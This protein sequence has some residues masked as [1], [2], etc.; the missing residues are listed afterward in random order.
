MN[1]KYELA[2]F[3]MDGTILDTLEDLTDATNYVLKQFGKPER[4]TKEV[5]ELLGNGMRYLLRMAAGGNTSDDEVKQMI[6]VFY[7]YY[8]DHAAI[9][10]K[11]YDGIVKA[12]QD[13]RSRGIRTAVVSNKP[14]VAVRDLSQMY[15][16]GLFDE[17]VGAS[18]EV[19][20]KPSPDGVNLVLQRLGVDRTNAVYIG[21]SEVDYATSQNAQMDVIM[22]SWG[23]R[24]KEDILKLG[25]P[26]VVDVP[27]EIVEKI[28]N[29]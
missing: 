11:P 23:F 27:S 6:S 3:D 25:A 29:P 26:I 17:A 22:V 10:T 14:D 5:R 16:P 19:R 18:E 21:D 8:K 28:L 4:T 1:M 13:I 2:V 9:K 24:D 20:T 12:I 15:F 7:P